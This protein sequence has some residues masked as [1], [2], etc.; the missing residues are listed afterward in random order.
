MVATKHSWTFVLSEYLDLPFSLRVAGKPV[1]SARSYREALACLE[2][3]CPTE[4]VVDM[5][6]YCAQEVV[7]FARQRHPHVPIEE[8]DAVIGRLL[9]GQI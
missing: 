6:T 1:V 5:N 4:I 2:V 3:C 7:S 8:D 9:T